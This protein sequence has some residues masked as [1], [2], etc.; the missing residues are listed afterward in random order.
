M[1][2][3]LFQ[4]FRR[5]V[6]YL[7]VEGVC[8][9]IDTTTNRVFWPQICNIFVRHNFFF[10][11]RDPQKPKNVLRRLEIFHKRNR[12]KFLSAGTR[13]TLQTRGFSM[14]TIS[15]YYHCIH[16]FKYLL[17]RFLIKFFLGAIYFYNRRLL[18]RTC[19]QIFWATFNV[20]KDNSPDRFSFVCAITSS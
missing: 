8:A 14:V 4:F 18:V 16:N 6:Y 13:E 10:P 12:N 7:W 1:V 5:Q 9:P 15:Y 20:F 2:F 11:T 19:D 17:K 3:F